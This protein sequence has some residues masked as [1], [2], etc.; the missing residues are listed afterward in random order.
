MVQVALIL[1]GNIFGS[2]LDVRSRSSKKVERLLTW[3]LSIIES[4]TFPERYVAAD[5]TQFHE[6]DHFELAHA[7]A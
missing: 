6:R 2:P 4:D 3:G 1:R 5:T 7:F